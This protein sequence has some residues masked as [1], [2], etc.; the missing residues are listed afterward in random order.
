MSNKTLTQRQ[1]EALEII[2][3]FVAQNGYPPSIRELADQLGLQSSSTAFNLLD[4]LVRKGFI[5]KG[6]GPRMLRV[7]YQSEGRPSA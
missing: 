5:N 6:P 1:S 4:Q 7:I 2:K 3:S